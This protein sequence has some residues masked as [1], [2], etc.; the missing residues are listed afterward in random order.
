[1]YVGLMAPFKDLPFVLGTTALATSIGQPPGGLRTR[2]GTTQTTQVTV[3][4][5]EIKKFAWMDTARVEP[6]QVY[7]V[8]QQTITLCLGAGEATGRICT[9]TQAVG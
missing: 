1:M 7:M 8:G 3:R 9:A 6:G 2:T 4:S 5:E